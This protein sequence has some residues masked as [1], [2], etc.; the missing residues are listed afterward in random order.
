[1]NIETFLSQLQQSPSAITF[2]QT[3]DII[4][5]YYSYTPTEFT[6]GDAVNAA[7]SNEGSCKLFAFAKLQQLTP[8]QT[9]ACFGDYYR[10]DVLENPEGSDHANI[11]NFMVSGW[12][13]VTFE[14]A[15]L[16]L[17]AA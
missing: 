10:K 12:D 11:R 2:Q 9:L 15:A 1:M 17:K 5:Q 8:E 4:E 16:V 7:G 14:Q 13:G 3:M 6:N